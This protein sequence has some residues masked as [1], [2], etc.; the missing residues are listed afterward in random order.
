MASTL[1]A[2]GQVT[3]PQKVREFLGIAP[4]SAVDFELTKSG[5]VLLRPAKR[6]ARRPSSRFSKLR[7]RATIKMRTEQ[8]MALTRGE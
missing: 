7:G 5:D 2:K 6:G 8:I 3:I 4:G 1:T